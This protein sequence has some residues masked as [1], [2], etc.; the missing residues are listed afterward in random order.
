MGWRMPNLVW[1][2]FLAGAMGSA[3]AG[4]AAPSSCVKLILPDD[5]DGLACRVTAA[6]PVAGSVGALRFQIQEYVDDGAVMGAGVAVFTATSGDAA[7]PVAEAV[8]S[9]ARFDAPVQF[10]NEVGV[11]LDLNAETHGT[12]Q[13]PLGRL[14]IQRDGSW[15]P[16]DIDSWQQ[17]LAKRLPA[18]MQVWR[19]PF[20]D[21]PDFAASAVVRRDGGGSL[22]NDEG[23]AA[24][25]LRFRD[26]K[27]TIDN[28]AWQIGI[29]GPCAVMPDY[30]HCNDKGAH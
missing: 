17:E 7:R 30:P 2:V 4:D 21:Y 10:R 22:E 19:G 29:D 12:G 13:F 23:Y 27:L 3:T 11:F 1:V 25:L 15:A 24:V 6:G 16:V 8:A 5:L 9:D 26:G 14:F 28:A 20:P 18:G